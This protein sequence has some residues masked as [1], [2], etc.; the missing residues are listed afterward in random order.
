MTNQSASKIKNQERSRRLYFPLIQKSKRSIINPHSIHH[1]RPCFIERPKRYPF[2]L[3]GFPLLRKEPINAAFKITTKIICRF[4]TYSSLS[5]KQ[6][7]SKKR[8][9][10]STQNISKKTP[11]L[12]D[13]IGSILLHATILLF[14]FVLPYLHFTP[15][16]PY[17]NSNQGNPVDVVFLPQSRGNS[18]LKGEGYN[19]EPSDQ[20]VS[21][22]PPPTSLPA[23]PSEP[24]PPVPTPTPNLSEA[25][26][27]NITPLP[28]AEPIPAQKVQHPPTR[29]K[30]KQFRERHYTYRYNTPPRP[31]SQP[32]RPSKTKNP[33]DTLTNLNFDENPNSSHRRVS[34]IRPQGSRSAINMST[35]PLVK[36]GK[37][38]RPYSTGINIKGVSADYGDEIAAWIHHHM[39]YPLEALKRG[40]D[41]SPSVHVVINRD[42]QVLSISLTNSSGS[43]ALD[44]A[45]TGMFRNA[46]LP[47]IPPDLPDH[48]DMDLQINY[49]LLRQ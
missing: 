17:G 29:H 4:L 11:F 24:S 43:D 45:I 31:R 47:K 33:F 46:Q 44:A 42:G 36:N 37:I 22:P 5:H 15:K 3:T 34:K 21:V 20:P 48:F 1:L 39:F 32:T 13:S 38:N 49:I 30:E 12:F 10:L 8:I 23:V 14:I 7:I 16:N 41:G 2:Y 6:N 35:G 19:G 25:E 40:E 26:E 9:P 28:N 18:G 27:S